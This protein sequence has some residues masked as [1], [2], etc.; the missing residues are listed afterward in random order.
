MSFYFLAAANK[1]GFGHAT[2]RIDAVTIFA[3]TFFPAFVKKTIQ[4]VDNEITDF[5]LGD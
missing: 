3:L 1:Y 4:H 5:S 2:A